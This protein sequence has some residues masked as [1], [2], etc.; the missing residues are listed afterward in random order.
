MKFFKTAFC[1]VVIILILI[2]PVLAVSVPKQTAGFYVNDFAGVMTDSTEALIMQNSVALQQKTGAQ[3]V[4]TTVSDLDGNDIAEYSLSMLR[5][6]DIGDKVKNN[7][8]LIL[9]SV[10]DRKSRIEVGYGLEGRFPDAKTGRIQDNY[11][12]TYYKTG[13]FDSGLKNGYLAVLKEVA[14][15]YGL[16]A[17]FANQ[18]APSALP[19]SNVNSSSEFFSSPAFIIIMIA[20]LLIDWIFLH[21]AISRTLFWIIFAFGRGGRGGGFGGGGGGYSGGGGSGGGGGSSRGF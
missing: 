11:M 2:T 8:I 14:A 9:L 13:D 16:D 4:V 6:W 19:G 7:G 21:G 18:P 10:N 12:L 5:A 3:I 17:A 20:L 1:A 15:E